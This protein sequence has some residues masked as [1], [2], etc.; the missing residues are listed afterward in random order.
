[1]TTYSELV[2]YF[3]ALTS[4]VA[5]LSLVRVGDDEAIIELQNTRIQYPALWVETPSVRFT[6]PGGVPAK[7]FRFA[8]V[9]LVNEPKKTAAEA[10]LKLSDTLALIEL[11]Y[12]QIL[13]DAEALDE[14]VLVLRESDASPITRWS[15]DN[16]YGWRMEI[17]I[18]IERCECP[19]D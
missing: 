13:N 16:C 7:R 14:F 6:D 12:A 19:P 10:N 17:D 15:A 4:H 8:L 5:G 18:E 1:M 9:V 11:V 3:E 2:A